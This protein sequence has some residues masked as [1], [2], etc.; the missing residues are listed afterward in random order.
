MI[1]V[2]ELTKWY[3]GHVA[4]DR[5][6][7]RCPPAT[8]TGFLGANGAGKS[9]VMRILVGLGTATSGSATIDG[10]RYRDIPDPA[11]RVGILL[12]ASAQHAG[13]TG[14]EV[15]AMSA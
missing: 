4:V 11:T 12:D 15:L 9:T 2:H 3:G 10:R 13:R 5:V 1:D 14:R 7:F 6:T 8:V